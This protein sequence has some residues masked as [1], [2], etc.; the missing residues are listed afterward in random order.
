MSA[1]DTFVKKNGIGNN[2]LERI[3]ITQEISTRITKGNYIKY[4]T[5]YIAKETSQ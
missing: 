3:Q 5:F 4:K 2:S 1:F